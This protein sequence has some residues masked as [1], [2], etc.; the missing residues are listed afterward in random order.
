MIHITQTG[1]ASLL[2][3]LLLWQK[4][5]LLSVLALCL[6][7][8]PTALYM[9]EL[10]K[11]IHIASAEIDG[12]VPSAALLKVIQ[13]TQQHRGLSSMTLSGVAGAGQKRQLKQADVDQAMVNMQALMSGI[14]S[15][16]IQDSW[17]KAKMDWDAVRSGV[18]NGSLAAPASFAAHTNHLAR[19]LNL[20]ERMADYYGLSVDTNAENSELV[21]AMFFQLPALA[22]ETG[23]LRARGSAQ[24]SKQEIS[25]EDKLAIASLM[26][27]MDDRLRETLSGFD[28]AIDI[29]PSIKT[30]ID[31]GLQQAVRLT[32]DLKT[33]AKSQIV[34]AT[35]MSFSSSQFFDI[36][37][38]TI[39]AQY[40]VNEQA[41][42]EIARR[43]QFKVDALH[44]YS[45]LTSG[46]LLLLL[47]SAAAMAYVV[48]KSISRPL[49]RATYLAQRVAA[50]DLTSQFEVVGT[51][52]IAQLMQ[53]L[54]EMN[55]S[56]VRIVSEIRTGTD[57]IA[58]ASSE[59]AS[60]NLDLSTRTEHQASSLE[61]TASSI[62]ELTS[63]VR[64]NSDN[65]RR[66]SQ[67]A[68]AA[69]EVATRG[70]S[71]VEQVVATMLG[72]NASSAKIVDIIGVID[73]IA[74]QTNILAL[75]A[76]VEAARAGEQGRGFAVVA[77]EVRNLAQR[78][79]A[80]AKEIK[81][82]IN[83]SVAKVGDGTQ[84][85][86]QAGATMGEIV[87]SVH[88]VTNLI[89]DIA[90]A[91]E[92]QIA[93]IEQVNHAIAEIDATT[94]HNAALVEQASAAAA[95]LREQAKM[96]TDVVSVFQLS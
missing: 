82:L 17:S 23:K 29:D 46:I 24:L 41:S 52:E 61:E 71:V 69:G 16:S 83:D 63:T 7:V 14:T 48:V 53:A 77:S 73:G 67:M 31:D 37:T 15:K 89:S 38:K 25:F 93:G 10:H 13:L 2:D 21:H 18:A 34:D 92:E 11:S 58:T 1:R 43:L 30:P 27:R 4:F 8:L 22:E 60:G 64:Q 12:L 80:A 9:R 51:N 55:S 33:L 66:A 84:L 50:G 81:V 74:F 45:Y 57:V 70:G 28:K 20:N 32:T 35:E 44:Q 94:Q 91:S 6:A 96:Q 79:A 3:N 75:N 40:A 86:N 68:S 88:R 85:V 87:A 76:A 78:S 49:A 54:R 47:A 62:E 90:S 95:S 26:G 36:A 42:K 56:L 19:L 39:D 72:I 5:A 65:A 59:I